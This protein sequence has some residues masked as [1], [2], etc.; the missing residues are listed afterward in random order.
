VNPVQNGLSNALTNPVEEIHR[1][2]LLAKQDSDI[3]Q[4]VVLIRRAEGVHYRETGGV[5]RR[6]P[7]RTELASGH[8]SG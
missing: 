8:A 5:S 1:F 4:A 2:H 7:Q 3:A 6:I